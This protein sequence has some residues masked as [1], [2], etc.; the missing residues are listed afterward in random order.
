MRGILREIGTIYRILDSISNVEFK[1]F[2]L[3]KGQYA[4]LVR[5]CEHPGIIQER[6][7]EMLKIDRATASRAIQKL[8]I[9]ELIIKRSDDFNKKIQLLYPTQR[10]LELFDI[11]KSEETYSNEVALKGLSEEE[12]DTLIGLLQRVQTNLEPEWTYVKKGNQRAYLK[13]YSN[14]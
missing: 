4:Y 9:A 14:Q 2:D 12:R 10:G 13:P 11:L 5:I 6:I 7:S 8:E 1:A 3:A